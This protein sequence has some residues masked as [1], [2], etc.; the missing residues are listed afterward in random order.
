MSEQGD[1]MEEK[2]NVDFIQK[3]LTALVHKKRRINDYWIFNVQVEQPP[4]LVHK[5]REVVENPEAHAQDVRAAVFQ[6]V[7]LRRY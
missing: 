5:I 1:E 6:G 7:V 2:I 3:S 4:G